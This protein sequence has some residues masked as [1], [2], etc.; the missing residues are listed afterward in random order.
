LTRCDVIIPNLLIIQVILTML[1]G[2]RSFLGQCNDC[3]N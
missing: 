1:T 2:N 3:W